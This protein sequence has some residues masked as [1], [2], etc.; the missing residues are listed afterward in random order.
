MSTILI[1]GANGSLAI[2]A[3]EYLLGAY[4][5]LTVILTA[6]DVSNEDRNTAELR[7]VIAKFPDAAVS[8]RK[9]DL[10]SLEEVQSFSEGLNKEVH[11]GKVPRLLAVLC[12]AMSW[13]L[14]GGPAYSKDG[15]EKTIAINHLAQFALSLR[16]LQSMDTEHGRIVFLGSVAHWPDKSALS[17]GF[18]T[19][20]PER[21]DWLVHPLSDE[22]GEEMGRGMQRYG[23]SKL[24]VLMVMYELNRR[25]KMVSTAS[26]CKHSPH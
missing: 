25:M 20:L 2:P 1:T 24:V 26:P 8:V 7:R 19:K 5:S 14:S 23:T 12:N 22:A 4:P 16:L 15:F 3:V 13:K 9:L 21:L 11:D 6:R 10:N 18:P 17:K